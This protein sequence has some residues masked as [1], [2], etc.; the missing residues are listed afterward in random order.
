MATEVA[1]ATF[2]PLLG[3][4]PEPIYCA[5]TAQ[6]SAGLQHKLVYRR[7]LPEALCKAVLGISLALGSI[8]GG[9]SSP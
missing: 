6:R 4:E 5:S 8:V 2:G 7:N 1:L 3:H 9:Q